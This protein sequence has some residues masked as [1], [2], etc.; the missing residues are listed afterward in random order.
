L[1]SNEEGSSEWAEHAFMNFYTAAS[2]GH[3]HA[4]AFVSLFYENALVPS[5]NVI[6]EYTGSGNPYEYLRYL[7]DIST[8]FAKPEGYTLSEFKQETSSKSL[9]NLYLGAMTD[10]GKKRNF[11]QEDFEE[12]RSYRQ[13]VMA[14]M[15][16]GYKYLY[17]LGVE[18]K[19]KASVLYY[20]EAALEAIA[21]VAQSN[22]LDVV[23]RKKL[24]I[25]PHVLLDQMQIVDS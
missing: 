23:E 13:S 10:L 9:I 11:D 15:M 7:S 3:K 1:E 16:L 22:G 6:Q 24:S 12:K 19:C 25:G 17:G 2:V 18:E 8:Q 5:H 20:E 4:R 21:Y 14:Q